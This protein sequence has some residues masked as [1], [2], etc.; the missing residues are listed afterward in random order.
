[1]LPTSHM[2]SSHLLNIGPEP[3]ASGGFSDVYL[4][5][6]N[7][8]RVCAKRIRVDPARVLE[9]AGVSVLLVLSLSLFVITNEIHRP[10]FK[11]PWCGNTWHTQTL[12][13][14][15]VSL[16]LPS[17]L[18]QNGCLGGTYGITSGRTPTQTDLDWYASLM[19]WLSSAYS[20]HQLSDIA[21][22]LRYLHSS[23]VIHG[24][25]KGVRGC[26][27]SR[28]TAILTP[29]QLDILVDAAGHARV[30]DFGL[31]I[32]TRNL[33]SARGGSDPRGYAARWAAP[34]VLNDGTC[35]KEADI[36]SFA[37]VMIEV[38]HG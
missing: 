36:F 28:P 31:A 27:K 23:N 7:G 24:D 22:G 6:L 29:D 38:R 35:G 21:K 37:M 20:Y 16:S 3:F 9:E 32:V 26:L 4:G 30:T 13:L 15:W 19:L 12:Y 1:M 10:S 25:L 11:R 34:E 2:L 17:S 14:S 33:D 18:F 8:S 5:T